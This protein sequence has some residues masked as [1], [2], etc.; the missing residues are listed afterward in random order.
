MSFP[1]SKSPLKRLRKTRGKGQIK[2]FKPQLTSL[3]DVMTIL[4][5][6]LLQSFSSEGEIV[7][8][9]KELDLPESSA[10]KK[11]ELRV[12]LIVNN[13]YILA[14]DQKVA[15]VSEVLE[16]DELIIPGLYNWLGNRKVATEKIGQYSS[17]T[18]FKGE[19]TIQGDKKIR[20]RLLKKIMYTCGQQ[21]FNNFS[22]AVR[23]RGE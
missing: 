18:K 10:Q 8:I 21:E 7:T 3:V 19:I 14:E 16:S 2:A 11:P 13:K 12:T 1:A 22:L 23:K 6:Y 9:S 5:I 15:D 20:F 17:K 4:L